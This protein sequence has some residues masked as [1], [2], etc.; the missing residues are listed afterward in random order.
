MRRL[1]PRALMALYEPGR[2]AAW[3]R[4]Y[5]CMPGFVGQVH[6]TAAR[7][8][9]DWYEYIL[10]G[11]IYIGIVPPDDADLWGA[12]LLDLTERAEYDAL[13]YWTPERAAAEF[14]RRWYAGT[15]YTTP[16]EERLRGE[17]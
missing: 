12:K 17:L 2:I 4:A 9:G 11:P 5:G 16:A 7:H 15:W 14:T 3:R 6:Y 8:H 10:R 1:P 13:V